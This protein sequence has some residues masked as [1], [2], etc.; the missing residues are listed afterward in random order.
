MGIVQF[1]FILIL[2]PERGTPLSPRPSANSVG[3]E[4]RLKNQHFDY[5]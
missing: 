3:I 4:R 1:S 2:H 5:C